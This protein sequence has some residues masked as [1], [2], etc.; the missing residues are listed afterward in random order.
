MSAA[1]HGSRQQL[2]PSRAGAHRRARGWPGR[3]RLGPRR[4]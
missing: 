3:R 1:N 2:P 4:R